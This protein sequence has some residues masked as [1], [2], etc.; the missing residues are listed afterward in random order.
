MK[1]VAGTKKSH[2]KDIHMQRQR[3]MKRYT[4]YK[5]WSKNKT[6]GGW[7]DKWNGVDGKNGEQVK[8]INEK[9]NATWIIIKD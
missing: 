2:A 6:G 8:K 4:R 7:K 1:E 9:I 5:E 3:I